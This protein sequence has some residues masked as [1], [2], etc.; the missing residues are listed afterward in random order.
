MINEIIEFTE[1]AK[2]KA[3]YAIGAGEVNYHPYPRGLV[4]KLI[5]R[6]V[7]LNRMAY[8]IKGMKAEP[9]TQ[10][11]KAGPNSPDVVS[12]GGRSFHKVRKKCNCP[13]HNESPE[14]GHISTNMC[15]TD[16]YKYWYE[17]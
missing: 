7:Q 10:E 15:C 2:E 13:C 14:I 3:L 4:V 11:I 6:L 12:I 9:K 16:G 5:D 17:D 8:V 1:T